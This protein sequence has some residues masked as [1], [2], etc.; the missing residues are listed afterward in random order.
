MSR[1]VSQNVQQS[2]KWSHF[3]FRRSLTL[4]RLETHLDHL[5]FTYFMWGFQ[6]TLLS[7]LPGTLPIKA[8][9]PSSFSSVLVIA[10]N[11]NVLFLSFSNNLL[12]ALSLL[13]LQFSS[14]FFT[15]LDHLVE[16]TRQSECM[17]LNP[18]CHKDETKLLNSGRLNLTK[19]EDSRSTSLPTNLTD[20]AHNPES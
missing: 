4:K 9:S 16:P 1:K 5:C 17:F 3:L 6:Q 2:N 11:I 19:A 7:L 12:K 13:F 10:K 15:Y 14:M 8:L 18:W 20:V